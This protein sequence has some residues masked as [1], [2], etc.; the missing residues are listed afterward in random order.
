MHEYKDGN[1]IFYGTHLDGINNLGQAYCK[2]VVDDKF[3]SVYVKDCLVKQ[4]EKRYVKCVGVDQECSDKK[5]TIG[6]GLLGAIIAG[7]IGA[8]VGALS[9]ELESTEMLISS[10]ETEDELRIFEA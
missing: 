10:I 9:A 5:S 7:P 3:V 1:L 6:R 4:F 8:F 2:I